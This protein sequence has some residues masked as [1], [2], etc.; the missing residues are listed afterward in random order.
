[1][2]ESYVI[3]NKNRESGIILS[4]QKCWLLTFS[5]AF[6]SLLFPCEDLAKK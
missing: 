4:E 5:K 6:E 1:M 2:L 3:L